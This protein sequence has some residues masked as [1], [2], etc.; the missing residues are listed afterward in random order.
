MSKEN[1][2]SDKA[3]KVNEFIADFSDSLLQRAIM[4]LDDYLNSGCKET[5]Q[6]ASKNAKY[7]Y[8]EYYGKDYV[9]RNDR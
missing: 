6:I 2:T 5:R 8:K 3:Q 1:E 4:T 7:I 9:N